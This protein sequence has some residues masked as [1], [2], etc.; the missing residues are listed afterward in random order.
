MSTPDRRPVRSPR[1]ELVDQTPVGGIYL[2]RLVRAQLTLS[3]V[4]LVAFGG[5]LGALPIA[6]YVVPSLSSAAVLG[7][8]WA[9]VLLGPPVFLV[10][11]G[12]GWLYARR[13]DAL[14]EAFRDLVHDDRP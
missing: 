8:P 1:D 2:R 9:I 5:L 4:S 12:V 11:L 6:L 7:V 14:D 10:L 3:L 13:A